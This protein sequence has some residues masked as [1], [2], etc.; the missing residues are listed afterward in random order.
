M[1]LCKCKLGDFNNNNFNIS[2][3]I[4]WQKTSL[5]SYIRI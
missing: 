5:Y 2:E 3:V 1:L 4:C